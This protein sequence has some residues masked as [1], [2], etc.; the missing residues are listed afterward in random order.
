MIQ[1]TLCRALLDTDSTISTVSQR[2]AE[3]Y[4]A[5]VEIQPLNKLLTIEC[6]NGQSLPYI[7]FVEIDLELD[8]P[9]DVALSEPLSVMML[10]VPT[11][12]YGSQVPVLLGTNV[13][14]PLIERYKEMFGNRYTDVTR[15]SSSLELVF[16]CMNVHEKELSRH[17]GR[18]SVLKCIT[19][20]PV[21]V[22]PNG[23]VVVSGRPVK[24]VPVGQC[25]AMVVPAERSVFSRGVEI[26]P[27]LI[28]YDNEVQEV[29]VVVQETTL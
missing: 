12:P 18:I 4:L 26:S 1:G 14:R 8:V 10:V 2:F 7:G 25:S 5:D 21:V 23:S 29:P 15:Y 20:S 27:L 28:R 22:H 13:L 19:S 24:R 11:T 16:R 17:E 9:S 3:L 6:A